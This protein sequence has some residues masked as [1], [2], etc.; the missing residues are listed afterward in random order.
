MAA[1]HKTSNI[2]V[3]ATWMHF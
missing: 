2:R 3:I 1:N